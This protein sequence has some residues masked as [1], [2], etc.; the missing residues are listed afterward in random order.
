MKN[1]E[2]MKAMCNEMT[3]NPEMKKMCRAAMK[4]K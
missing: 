2:S 1:P 4:K 3:K